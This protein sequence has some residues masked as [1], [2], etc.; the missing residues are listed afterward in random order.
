MVIAE[1]YQE[2]IEQAKAH[3][4]SDGGQLNQA[5]V[6]V[7]ASRDEQEK[8]NLQDEAVRET[9][10][11]KQALRDSLARFDAETERT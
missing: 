1:L 3:S 2:R 11:A 9:K 6:H 4:F 10:G 8:Q 5:I 7:H